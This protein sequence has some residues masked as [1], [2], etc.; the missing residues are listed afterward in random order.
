M[1]ENKQNLFQNEEGLDVVNIL[2]L[3]WKHKIPIVVLS[4]FFAIISVVRAMCFTNDTYTTTGVLYV[5]NQME[6]PIDKATITAN[7]IVV[8]RALGE[9]YLEILNTRSFFEEVSKDVGGKFSPKDISGMINVEII[10]ETELIRIYTTAL[11]PEDA[12]LVSESIFKKA[13]DRLLKVYSSGRVEVIDAPYFPQQP[14]GKGVT[15]KAVSGIILGFALGVIYI[16]IRNFFDTKVRSSA[17]VSRRYG[18]SILGEICGTSARSKKDKEAAKQETY[19][20][21][22]DSGFDT[23]ETYKAIRTNIMFSIPKSDSGKVVAVTS[24]APG[25]GKTT[26]TINLAKTFAQTGAKVL[27]IDSDLRKSRV[28]QYLNIEY[29][30]GVTNVLCG[31]CELD[32]AITK[33]VDKNLDVLL[34]GEVPPNPAELLASEEFD[35][36]LLELCNLYDYIFIDTPPITVVTDAAILMQKSHAAIIVVREN[37]TTYDLLDETMD[38]MQRTGVKLIGV[39]VVDSTAKLRKYGYYKKGKY[40]Y[41]SGYGYGY[42]EKTEEKQ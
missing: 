24:A 40:G 25:E 30:E 14:N 11:T 13:Q 37:Q 41:R 31:F 10:N 9:T 8:S 20:L 22:A 34:A 2:Q 3:L 33:D 12:Y 35:N 1:S 42:G 15:K 19:I 21:H 4:A 36:M 18:L 5:S 17:D 23:V 32:K 28:Q 7:D 26:T 39:V 16:F 29:S 6:A 27:L 38:N